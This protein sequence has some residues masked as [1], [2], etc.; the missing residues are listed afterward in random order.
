[1]CG[2]YIKERSHMY[3]PAQG[4]LVQILHKHKFIIQISVQLH[5]ATTGADLIW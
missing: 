2:E 3:Q 4:D 1:M 5:S